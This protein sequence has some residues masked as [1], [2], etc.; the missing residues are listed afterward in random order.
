MEE[1]DS[2]AEAY[3]YLD[4]AWARGDFED[5]YSLYTDIFGLIEKIE[6]QYG[7]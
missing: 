5:N 6:M 1:N 2:I 7:N 4:E 3:D